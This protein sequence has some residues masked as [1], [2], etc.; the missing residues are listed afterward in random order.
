M[1]FVQTVLA[2]EQVVDGICER[3][4]SEVIQRS[5]ELV[6]KITDFADGLIEGLKDVDWP[7]IRRKT[8]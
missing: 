3:C 8:R 6:F 5:A 4:K 2:N 1:R 7:S